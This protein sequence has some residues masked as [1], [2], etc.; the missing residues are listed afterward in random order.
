[1]SIGEPFLNGIIGQ[2]VSSVWRGVGSAIFLDLGVLSLQQR[3]DGAFTSVAGE[4]TLMIQWSW[5][6]SDE[7]SILLGS[8]SD[9]D[10]WEDCL[11]GLVGSRVESAEIFGKLP[12]ILVHLSCGRRIASFMMMDGQPSWALVYREPDIGTLWV[13]D[14]KLVAQPPRIPGSE[15]GPH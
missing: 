10:S 7:N 12:E 4:Q 2:T 5:R 9:E 14:G 15:L 1:M 8:W 13:D 3:R 6:I 11:Q